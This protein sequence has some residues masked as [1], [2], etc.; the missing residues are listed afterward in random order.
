MEKLPFTSYGFKLYNMLEAE[1]LLTENG[2]KINDVI[3][4][5]EKVKLSAELNADREFIILVAEKP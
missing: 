2:F 4:N 1:D 3:R 5:T